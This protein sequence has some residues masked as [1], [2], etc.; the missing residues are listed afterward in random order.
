M[1]TSPNN[2]TVKRFSKLHQKKYRDQENLMIVEGPHLVE[3]AQ[4]KVLIHT[5]FSLEAMPRSHST[6]VSESVMKKLTSTNHVPPVAAVVK[7]PI[8]QSLSSKVLILEHV[9]DPGNVGTL[10]RTALAFGFETVVLD[11]CADPFSSKVLRST[12]GAL[13]D[14]TLIE[15]DTKTFKNQHPEYTLIGTDLLGQTESLMPKLPYALILGN[16][17][18]G[19]KKSTRALCDTLVKIPIKSIDSLNVGIAGGIF[20]HSLTNA[21]SSIFKL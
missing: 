10:L 6:L 8:R 13:F 20:M 9:Q 12:Q 7:I 15:T 11:R 14:L 21:G 3:I 2:V 17:G 1:L 4:S 16:E 19:M 18:Q 5:I